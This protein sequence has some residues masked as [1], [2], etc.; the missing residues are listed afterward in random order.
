M[1]HIEKEHIWNIIK[2]R[3]GASN[4]INQYEIADKC[5]Y[6]RKNGFGITERA[7]RIIIRELRKEG[8]PILSTPHKPGG[9]FIPSSYV[10]AKDWLRWMRKK[11][12]KELAIIRPVLKSCNS[13]FPDRGI[14]QMSLLER[15]G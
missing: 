6:W 4:A 2:E 11:A 9:Y 3:I 8:Y 7:V 12:I 5:I 15:V 13:M 1:N 14:G 10:E